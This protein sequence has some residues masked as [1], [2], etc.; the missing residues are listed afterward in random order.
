MGRDSA[1]VNP[2]TNNASLFA[3]C[4]FVLKTWHCVLL[5]LYIIRTL[6]SQIGLTTD[7]PKEPEELESVIFVINLLDCLL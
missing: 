4:G 6:I 1:V 2:A 3:G 7:V 5:T